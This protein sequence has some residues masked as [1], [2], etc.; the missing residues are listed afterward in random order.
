MFYNITDACKTDLFY[1][2]LILQMNHIIST[3]GADNIVGETEH[4][5]N[6]DLIKQMILLCM[7]LGYS[8]IWLCVILPLKTE[9]L[10]NLKGNQGRHACISHTTAISSSLKRKSYKRKHLWFILYKVKYIEAN[11]QVC[12]A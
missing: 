4:K 3:I 12:G 6:I 7:K 10:S 1:N 5:Q 11:Q 9:N 2:I 8:L